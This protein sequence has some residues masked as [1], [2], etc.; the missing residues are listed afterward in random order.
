MTTIMELR[1]LM[2]GPSAV[3]ES[4]EEVRWMKEDFRFCS[5]ESSGPMWGLIQSHGGPCGVLAPVQAR[6]VSRILP[7]LDSPLSTDAS[8][9]LLSSILAEMLLMTTES[10]DDKI[11]L[12]DA[13]LVTAT[14]A[15]NPLQSTQ[16]HRDELEATIVPFL[17]QSRHG[18]LSFVYSMI[19]TRQP[20]RLKQDMDDNGGSLTMGEFGHG[21]QELLN[22]MLTGRA[23]SNAFDGVVPMGDT[24]LVLRGVMDRPRIGYLTQLEALRYCA[25]GSYYKTPLAPVWVLGSSS[26]FTVLFSTDASLV[27]ESTSDALLARVQ[28][29]FKH[30]DTME[31]GFIL[32]DNLVEC[33]RTLQVDEG[34]LSNQYQMGRLFAKIEV[35]GA[36]IVLWEDFWRVVSILLDTKDLQQALTGKVEPSTRPRSDSDIARELQAQFDN[37]G[38]ASSGPPPTPAPA[39][40]LPMEEESFRKVVFHHYNGLVTTTNPVPRLVAFDAQIPSRNVVGYS[41]PLVDTSQS[42]GGLGCPIED[43]LRTKWPGI[44]INWRGQTPPRLD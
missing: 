21:T 42:S 11:W 10:L 39:K 22:L 35:P 18:V 2:W 34:I 17:S 43:V 9:R 30:F 8:N 37:E 15:S 23:T 5:Q 1:E 6:I 28:R 31:S 36:G 20:S 3:Y 7:S 27:Q 19:L 29:A 25:V 44:E 40:P 4:E 41:V 13:A 32:L 24:G 14:S 16:V 12:I 33:L 38:T 26:H